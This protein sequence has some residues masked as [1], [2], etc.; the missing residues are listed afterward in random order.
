MDKLFG[1]DQATERNVWTGTKLWLALPCLLKGGRRPIH[2]SRAK[3]LSIIKEQISK[4]CLAYARRIRED[5][6]EHRL[7]L[8]RRTTDNSQ[9]F[10]GCRLL[11]QR[12]P[13]LA[14][15]VYKLFFKIFTGV[16]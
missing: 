14:P 9:H 4:F 1:C 11:F 7:Q 12:F 3:R 13:E 16:L 2:R 10:G 8:A 15:R 5:D 6:L